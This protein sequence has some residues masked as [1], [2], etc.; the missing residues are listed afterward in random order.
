MCVTAHSC[1]RA[2]SGFARRSA[3]KRRSVNCGGAVC[4]YR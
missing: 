4:C 1:C 3:R 2:L